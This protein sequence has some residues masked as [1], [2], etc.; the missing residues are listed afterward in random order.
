MFS[1]KVILGMLASGRLRRLLLCVIFADAH[2]NFWRFWSRVP[3][4][5]ASPTLFW[6]WCPSPTLHSPTLF[7]RLEETMVWMHNAWMQGNSKFT[8]EWWKIGLN[9]AISPKIRCEW[10][11]V[12]GNGY[13]NLRVN[14][15][16][17]HVN[18]VWTGNYAER[19]DTLKNTHFSAKNSGI[20]NKICDFW[21]V[22]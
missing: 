15:H 7:G 17:S 2:C 8:C 12:N 18:Y 13:Q 6:D 21:N 10:L 19:P 4:F 16:H 20:C 1:W 11:R 5:F 22:W 14:S 3:P 9:E